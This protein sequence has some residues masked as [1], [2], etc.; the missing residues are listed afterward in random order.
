MYESFLSD[1]PR[2]AKILEVG[3]NTG[4]Q[5]VGLQRMG[6]TNL[7]GIELQPFAIELSKKKTRH[8]NIIKGSALDLPF[9]DEYFDLV[10][11][12]GVLIHISPDNLIKVMAEMVRCTNAYLLGFEYYAKKLESI[13]YRG[14][15]DVLW[16]ADYA[17]LFLNNFSNLEL[18][19][20]EFYE[21][22]EEKSNKDAMYLLR[23]NISKDS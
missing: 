18:M 15:E 4:L 10:F 9:K 19:K 8:I 14:N 2:D 17:S 20:K 1:L 16:K 21:Y 22:V 12:S 11:T 3:S 5:L 13:S 7:Y 6:F 23:K